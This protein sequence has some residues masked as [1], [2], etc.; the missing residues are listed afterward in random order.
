LSA[1]AVTETDVGPGDGRAD[2]ERSTV[3][4]HPDFGS[5]ISSVRSGVPWGSQGCRVSRAIRSARCAKAPSY[6]SAGSGEK[7]GFETEVAH[8]ELS[9]RDIRFVEAEKFGTT[10]VDESHFRFDADTTPLAAIRPLLAVATRAVVAIEDDVEQ[11]LAVGTDGE[12]FRGSFFA[13]SGS[14]V[15]EESVRRRALRILPSGSSR[16][17]STT[18]CRAPSRSPDGAGRSLLRRS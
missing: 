8:A 18:T 17:S 6:I 10:G 5:G 12:T 3:A 2:G 11:K 16:R 9:R 7:V 15:G 4:A 1:H 14:K 13:G